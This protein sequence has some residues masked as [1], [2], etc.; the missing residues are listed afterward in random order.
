MI[1]KQIFYIFKCYNCGFEENLE[2][3]HPC[4]KCG[5]RQVRKNNYYQ[6]KNQE[7]EIAKLAAEDDGREKISDYPSNYGEPDEPEIRYGDEEE[8]DSE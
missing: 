4:P 5:G 7:Q 6:M 2:T 8:A 1:T 3:R